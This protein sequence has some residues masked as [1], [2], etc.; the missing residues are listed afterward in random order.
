M[1]VVDGVRFG[2][3]HG[4]KPLKVCVSNGIQRSHAC[5]H[6]FDHRPDGRMYSQRSLYHPIQ[7]QNPRGETKKEAM[8]FTTVLIEKCA[9]RA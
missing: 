8:R 4:V 9:S 2:S 5:M 3:K 7:T 6:F 1:G